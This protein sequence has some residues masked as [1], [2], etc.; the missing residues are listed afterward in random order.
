M[1]N[2]LNQFRWLVVGAT[3]LLGSALITKLSQSNQKVI[4]L[5][6]TRE[7]KVDSIIWEHRNLLE[8][9]SAG[10]LVDQYSPSVVI[11]ATGLTNVD[12]CEQ[13]PI[14]A[15]K[16]NATVPALFAKVCQQKHIKF[17]YISTDHLFDGEKHFYQEFSQ[18]C[19]LNVYA[20]TKLKGEQLVAE[21]SPE[22][23]I[24]RTNF[25]GK[26]PAW[27][28]SFTDWLS[29]K[30]KNNQP[31]TAFTDTYFTPIYIPILITSMLDLVAR[32]AS[33]VFNVAGSERLSKYDFAVQFAKIFGYDASLAQP[34][35]VSQSK[36]SAKRPLDMSL[37][38]AKVTE[39]L[40]REMPTIDEGLQALYQGEQP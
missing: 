4:A 24:L 8:Y 39:F 3:G 20:E 18:P 1:L 11:Y 19:P 33:G 34:G 9:F 29:E 16:L 32:N 40:A 12:Q 25:Y 15:M 27:R 37:S 38:V 22:A 30:F 23:L 35:L 13:H 5:S 6:N 10:D 36:L 31:F 17:I 7:L 14:D 28:G 21:N 26:G 2:D